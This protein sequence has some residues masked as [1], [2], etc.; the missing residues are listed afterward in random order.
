MLR[1]ILKRLLFF[2]PSLILI[3]LTGFLLT[4][5]SPGDPLTTILH[6]NPD[7]GRSGSASP[8]L[9]KAWRKKLGLDLPLFY[10]SVRSLSVPDTLRRIPE[11]R[12]RDQFRRLALQYGNP[13]AVTAYLRELTRFEQLLY[14]EPLHNDSLLQDA[15]N[16]VSVLS[17]YASSK[18]DINSYFSKLRQIEPYFSD[19]LKKSLASCIQAFDMLAAEASGWKSYIPVIHIHADNQYHRWLFGDGNWISG[20][21]ATISKGIIRGDFGRSY[22]SQQPI[23]SIIYQK[24]GWTLFFTIS[25][26]IVAYAVSI[27][28]GIFATMERFRKFDRYSSIILY[29]LYSLPHFFV[30]TFLMMM[31]A[32]PD[33]FPWF[34]SSG[35]KPPGGYPEGA[36]F[37][38]KASITLPYLVLP[39]IAYT[40][41]SFAYLA[42]IF[43]TGLKEIMPQEYIKTAKAKGLSDY[44]VITRHALRNA[45]F[46]MITVFAHV[47]PYLI[48]G[49]VILET[50]FTIPGMGFEIYQSIATQNYPMIIA[51]FTLSGLLTLIGFLLSDVLYALTDPRISYR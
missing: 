28:L 49:S 12:E 50:I 22:I 10:I 2:I 20:K 25:S 14:N 32:N 30:A 33:V 45:L 7:E 29:F 26:L 43:R 37:M 15:Q 23:G 1:Y 5:Y 31:F 39:L 44:A 42:R 47:L 9:K 38:E 17:S 21:G 8:E 40:Y 36:G 11:E 19:R 48:G 51:V 3:T 16:Q 24:I 13:A 46:P 4:V 6:T 35:L 41:N 27:P 34:P 18:A